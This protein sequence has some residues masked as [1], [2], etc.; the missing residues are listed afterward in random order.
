MNRAEWEKRASQIRPEF[1]HTGFPAD[2]TPSAHCTPT[3]CIPK[4][5][6]GNA[7]SR[8]RQ[9]QEVPCLAISNERE[10]VAFR[11]SCQR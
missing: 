8:E 10:L 1:Q 2:N 6:V 11:Q 9:V 7:E 5:I 4:T 3:C